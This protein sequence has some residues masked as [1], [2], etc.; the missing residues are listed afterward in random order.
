MIIQNLIQ[1]SAKVSNYIA[2]K[3]CCPIIDDII[4]NHNIFI[5]DIEY[6]SPEGIMNIAYDISFNKNKD[7]LNINQND[8]VT[9]ISDIKDLQI[10]TKIKNFLKI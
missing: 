3:I 6:K 5:W 10:I 9:K 8:F 2:K 1:E 7:W 4:N